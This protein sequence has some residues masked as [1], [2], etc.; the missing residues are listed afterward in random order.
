VPPSTEHS[1]PAGPAEPEKANAG[2]AALVVPLGP[3]S[4]EVPGGTQ[5]AA[6]PS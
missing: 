2:A 1:N 3:E 4:I 5:S 6:I